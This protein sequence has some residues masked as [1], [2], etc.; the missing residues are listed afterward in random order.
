MTVT[1]VCVGAVGYIY[2]STTLRCVG[3][4]ESKAL[5]LT[6][7]GDLIKSQLTLSRLIPRRRRRQL[8]RVRARR[9]VVATDA[10]E[11]LELELG[12][13]VFRDVLPLDVGQLPR[14]ADADLPEHVEKIDSVFGLE[15]FQPL[16]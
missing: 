11:G 7:Q 10:L 13:A 16:G 12:D 6:F 9:C 14:L 15:R 3:G 8:R 5:R 2:P 1:S 4:E